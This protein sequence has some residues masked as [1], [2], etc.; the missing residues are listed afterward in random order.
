MRELNRA[1]TDILEIRTHIAAGTAFRGYGP[2]A[3]A[4]T[5]IIGFL[6]AAVQS[7]W[8]DVFAYSAAVFITF[9][10]ATGVICAITV[11]IEMQGRSRRIHSYLADA[12]I[13]QALEQFLPATAASLLVPFFLLRFAPQSV[14][15]MP[16]L[17]QL[18]VG[19]GIFASIR[20]L[21]RKLM[22]G[23]IWF[24]VSAFL[25]LILASQSQ[26]LSP[27]LMGLPFLGGQLLMAVLLFATEEA[28]SE[29]G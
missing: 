24:F 14:W 10:I 26:A 1:L 20:S 18:F 17:W 8:P 11:W 25:S 2:T 28:T 15:M 27:W 5:G 6:A 12:M 3:V 16:G 19:L 22:L 7:R 23:G 9:W 21:P 29:E 13:S 4:A